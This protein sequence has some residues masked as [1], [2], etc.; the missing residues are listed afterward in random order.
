MTDHNALIASNMD[1][2]KNRFLMV[3]E[4]DS[5]YLSYLSVL[6][7][8]FNYPSFK[9]VTAKEAIETAATAVPFL[10]ITSLHLPDMHG[11][12]L[13]QKLK[14][15]P[16][17]SS[18][19][20][21]AVSNREDLAARKRCLELGAV[22]CLFHPVDAE[23]LYRVVQVAVE[24]NPRAHMR[25]RTVQPVKV[26]DMRHDNLYGA[27]TLDLSER[28]MFLRTA[29]PA[30]IDSQLS[31]HL[32]LNGRV[33]PTEAQVLYCCKPGTGPYQEPGIGVRFTRIEPKDQEHIRAFIRSEVT[34]GIAPANA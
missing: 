27:Y 13:I 26:N 29:N 31:L 2:R 16:S 3:V 32:D 20:L 33:I 17:T 1:N 23:T 25:V 12:D 34:R 30:S 19:P 21:I 15:N 6:L 28:G 14:E 7:Q 8:R 22:G 5:Y 9:A 10:V 4:S 24:K 11:F 18:V